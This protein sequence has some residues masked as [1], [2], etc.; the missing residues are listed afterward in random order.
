MPPNLSRVY[1]SCPQQD[2]GSYKMHLRSSAGPINVLVINQDKGLSSLIP[3]IPPQA[4]LD[5][6]NMDTSQAGPST[7]ETPPVRGESSE[8]PKPED[9][10]GSGNKGV[11]TRSRRRQAT[12]AEAGIYG[13]G[14]ATENNSCALETPKANDR[15]V[16]CSTDEELMDTNVVRLLICTVTELCC[17]CVVIHYPLYCMVSMGICT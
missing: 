11:V 14:A 3:T 13:G 9:F 5:Q 17:I 2:H 10:G 8:G 16:A 4:T 6:D 12:L 15:T 7:E 1:C